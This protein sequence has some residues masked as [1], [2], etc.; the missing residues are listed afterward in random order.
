MDQEQQNSEHCLEDIFLLD[1]EV[2]EGLGDGPS[3]GSYH[4]AD[5]SF[6]YLEDV[7][8]VEQDAAAVAAIMMIDENDV[9]A[10]TFVGTTEEEES[11]LPPDGDWI[12]E[13]PQDPTKRRSKDVSGDLEP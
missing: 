1:E 7:V 8:A 4:L 9:S 11:F 13:E 2:S 12:L 5:Q 3:Q 10:P 6:S